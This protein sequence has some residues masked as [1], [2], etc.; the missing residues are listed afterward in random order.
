M[1]LLRGATTGA[2]RRKAAVLPVLEQVI[3]RKVKGS[4]LK[5]AHFLKQNEP[6]IMLLSRL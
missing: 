1:L 5:N 3:G 4:E 6:V 2:S